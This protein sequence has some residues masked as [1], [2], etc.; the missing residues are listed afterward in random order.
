MRKGPAET[1]RAA[2]SIWKLGGMHRNTRVSYKTHPHVE[3]PKLVSEHIIWHTW[4]T[5]KNTYCL[6]R[7]KLWISLQSCTRGPQAWLAMEG[8]L[9]PRGGFGRAPGI[10]LSSRVKTG[11]CL[12]LQGASKGT[13][14]GGFPICESLLPESKH[15]ETLRPLT[16]AWWHF[17]GVSG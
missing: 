6:W 4:R 14:W 12:S 1:H 9:L 5:W 10:C 3:F 17:T 11:S 8:L 7:V 15:W 16:G 13:L 2:F